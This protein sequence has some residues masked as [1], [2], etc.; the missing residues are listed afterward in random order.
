MLSS[1][2]RILNAGQA[3]KKETIKITKNN[4]MKLKSVNFQRSKC[5]ILLRI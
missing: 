4:Y 2:N 3:E 1:E 5:L